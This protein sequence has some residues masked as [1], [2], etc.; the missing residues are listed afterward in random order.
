MHFSTSFLRKLERIDPELREI[1]YSLIDEIEKNREASV[2]K[3]DFNELKQIVADLGITVKEL[4][5][6]QKRTEARVEELAE[7]QKRTEARVEELAEAQKRTEAR[8][9]ELA[10]A[11]KKTEEV[12]KRL[13]IDM[14]DVKKQLGGLS[15]AV[16]YGI[17]DKIIPIIPQFI[18]NEFGYTV[19]SVERE[20]IIYPDGSYD[21]VNILAECKKDNRKIYI[22]GE[23]KAQPGKKDVQRFSKLLE[24]IGNHFKKP[25]E[26]FLVGYIFSPEVEKY[27]KQNHPEIR[28]YKTYQIERKANK[29]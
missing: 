13:V 8:V 23:C 17:E 27:I 29:K 22:V 4:A 28:F 19:T 10:E 21:E 7:A 11:Q 16:G 12:V 14:D 20:N 9:E 24:R 3:K 18:K 15:M 5:E 26:G 25:V 2:D 1:L 6:A